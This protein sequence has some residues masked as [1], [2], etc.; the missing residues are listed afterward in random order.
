M[1]CGVWR[2]RKCRKENVQ[3][4]NWAYLIRVHF[5][6]PDDFDGDFLAS[7]GVASSIDIA[8]GAVA[9]LLDQHKAFQARVSGHFAGFFPFLSNESFNLWVPSILLNF[10]L[11]S[12]CLCCGMAGLSCN[13]AVVACAWAYGELAGVVDTSLVMLLFL[14]TELRFTDAVSIFLLVGVDGRDVCGGMVAGCIISL[15]CLR[16]LAMSEKVFNI[17]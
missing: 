17:L 10:L 13:I 14:V 5:E 9:H 3:S 2:G 15:A 12:L 16:A 7:L 4:R 11:P 6:L 8:E 1:D